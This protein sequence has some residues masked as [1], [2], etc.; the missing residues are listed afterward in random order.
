MNIFCM[1]LHN[2]ITRKDPGKS[3]Q[4]YWYRNNVK[5]EAIYGPDSLLEVYMENFLVENIW[6]PNYESEFISEIKQLSPL[7][8]SDAT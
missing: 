3:M 1:R 7:F 6:G 2:L 5:N 8:L 4:T